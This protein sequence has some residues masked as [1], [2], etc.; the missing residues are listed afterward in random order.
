MFRL[1]TTYFFALVAI[2]STVITAD[3]ATTTIAPTE[4]Y[5]IYP[6]EGV[7]RLYSANFGEMRANHFH[8][9]V[10]IKS[11]G[12]V[13]RRIVATA[14]GYVSRITT[15]PVG[16][17]LSIYVAH[18]NGTT[19]QYG[20]LLK[21]RDDIQQ[22]VEDE[23][24]KSR[25][26]TVNI[27]LTPTQ[28][29]VKQGDLIA[30]SGNSGSS[31]GPHLHYE[32]RESKEQRPLNP[33]TMGAIKP[34]DTIKPTF[35]TL[36]YIESE[37]IDGVVYQNKMSEYKLVLTS[38]GKYQIEGD[39]LVW[40]GRE[41]HFVVAALDRKANVRNTFGLYS[42]KGYKSGKSFYEY[43]QDGFLFADTRYCNSVSYYP[44]QRTSSTAH[45]R[46]RRQEGLPAKMLHFTK[47]DGVIRTKAGEQHKI[48]IVACD[49]MGN[50]STLNFHI[51]GKDDKDCFKAKIDPT[52]EIAR[53]KS[54]SMFMGD[55]IEVKIPSG[56]LYESI[57][58]KMSRLPNPPTP[59]KGVVGMKVYSPEY[60]ILDYNTPL[61]RAMEISIDTA[62]PEEFVERAVMVYTDEKGQQSAIKGRY[63]DGVYTA[64][65]RVAG[66]HFVAT[67][68][69]APTIWVDV[70]E[71]SKVGDDGVIKMSVKDEFSGVASYEATINGEWIALDMHK[72][73]ITHKLRHKATNTTHKLEVRVVDLAGNEATLSRSFVW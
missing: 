18:P 37:T 40:V 50:S 39:K 49:D 7:A 21:F 11:D 2:C 43:Q 61:H 60:M 34:K 12:K 13:G 24:Y 62:I 30:Y 1:L 22:H 14:D 4:S 47:D 42:L 29:P 46:M 44:L 63:K 66:R 8:S 38:S 31:S 15:S 54:N 20:H 68:T 45:F 57:P 71:G 36:Y 58:F 59:A 17:G 67:D 56:V 23:R 6:M 52:T 41:G 19:T 51:R 10:D 16:Y 69:A 64:S 73:T 72:S 32:I 26:H 33:I 27:Y 9:G 70:A 48:S 35:T 25:K 65:S 53:A 28:F 55:N 5:Y 3:A